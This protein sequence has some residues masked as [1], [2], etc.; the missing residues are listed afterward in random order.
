MKQKKEQSKRKKTDKL[1]LFPPQNVQVELS[2]KNMKLKASIIWSPP[3][4]NSD[5]VGGYQIERKVWWPGKPTIAERP[6]VS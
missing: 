5:I 3:C 2:E 6:S 1:S 4:I